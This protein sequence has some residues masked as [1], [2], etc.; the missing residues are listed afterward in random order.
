MNAR[1]MI[2]DAGYQPEAVAALTQA[3]EDA[4]STIASRHATD[5]ACHER[6][7]FKLAGVVMLLGRRLSDPVELRD[8]ALRIMAQSEGWDA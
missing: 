5:H 8:V 6:L 1:R 2:A 3:F 7:R 4:W